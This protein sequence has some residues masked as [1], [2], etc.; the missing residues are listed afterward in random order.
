MTVPIVVIAGPTAAGKSALALALAERFNGCIINADSMQVYQESHIL[1]AR[2]SAKNLL[3]IPHLLYGHLPI[4]QACS[5]GLWLRWVN[6]IVTNPKTTNCPLFIVGGTGLYI[7]ALTNGLAI[8]PPVPDTIQKETMQLWEKLG[9]NGFHQKLQEVD[10]AMANRLH[11][12]DR[13]RLVRALSVYLATGRSLSDWWDK[14]HHPIAQKWIGFCL[15]PEREQ[16]YQACDQR[17]LQMMHHGALEEAQSIYNMHLS[18]QLPGLGILGLK[19]FFAYFDGAITLDQAISLSQQDTRN[20][21]KRQVTW[22]THQFANATPIRL[23]NGQSSS[24]RAVIKIIS[25]KIKFFLDHVGS[26]QGA[27][28]QH[29]QGLDG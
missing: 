2:P 26:F 3:S 24:E 12:N 4:N 8:I 17:F 15:L 7:R 22:F 10:S 29:L 28:P 11:P 18:P 19:R 13:Q 9:P 20:Y 6:D 21:A 5:V 25:E 1:S 16:L 23:E 27:Y 14:P